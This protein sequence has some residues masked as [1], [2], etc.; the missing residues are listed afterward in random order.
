MQRVHGHKADD[1]PLLTSQH[2]IQLSNQLLFV[3]A[4]DKHTIG[5][6]LPSKSPDVPL[7]HAFYDAEVEMP[8]LSVAELSKEGSMGSEVRLRRRD[9]FLEDNAS[10]K[11]QYI[12]K[13]RG[14]YFMKMYLKKDN[15]SEMD[16]VRR[17]A[18]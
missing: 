5:D 10:G 18:R 1:Q 7:I 13:R 16:F 12:V 6:E 3:F 2:P 15:Q 9:G 4:N 17:G 8:I 14:V 11:R